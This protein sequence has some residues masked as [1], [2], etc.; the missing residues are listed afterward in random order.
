MNRTTTNARYHAV[1]T[2]A[3]GNF[4]TLLSQATLFDQRAAEKDLS[5]AVELAPGLS[6]RR[7]TADPT[8]NNNFVE[9]REATAG[10]TFAPGAP[11]PGATY[12]T[13]WLR[14]KRTGSVMQGF[15]GPNGLDWTPMTA[16]DSATNVAGAY[17]VTV[18][19][20]LAVTS[21]NAAQTTEAVFHSF[22][23]ARVRPTLAIEVSGANVIVSWT[24]SALGWT[25]QASPGLVAP[26]AN[27]VNVPGS[28]AV[29]TVTLPLGSGT[30]FF[31][32]VP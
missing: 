9:Y 20:G 32:M 1:Y 28:S 30:R 18:R 22:G 17:P 12:P 25:L 7:F 14:L 19:L 31:R 16:V 10:T 13:N 8:R 3:I 29:N 15:A 2:A 5:F 23:K 11:R 27:W 6:A 4:I 24:P 21:H 26:D